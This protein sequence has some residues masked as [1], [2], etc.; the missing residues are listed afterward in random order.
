MPGAKT[1]IKWEQLNEGLVIE[2]PSGGM[3]NR[4]MVF[5]IETKTE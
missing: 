5:R 4:P 2:A 3:E 1:K